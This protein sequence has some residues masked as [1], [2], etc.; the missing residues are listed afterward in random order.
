MNM[1]IALTNQVFQ[2]DNENYIGLYDSR[3][4]TAF[5]S[6]KFNVLIVKEDKVVRQIFGS[7]RTVFMISSV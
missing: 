1:N 3:G 4:D 6:V 5:I 2:A 7:S